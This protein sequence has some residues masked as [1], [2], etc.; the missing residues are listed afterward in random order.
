[1]SAERSVQVRYFASMREQRGLGSETVRTEAADPGAL[2]RELAEAHRFNLSPSLV[3]FAINGEFVEADKPLNDG[4]ELCL[5]P[6][7]AGG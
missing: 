7:V 6:P 2:Y 3:R 1:M 4:D 5:I